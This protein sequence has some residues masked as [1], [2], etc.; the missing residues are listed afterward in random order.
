[1][2][3]EY[4]H[5]LSDLDHVDRNRSSI[6]RW[7]PKRIES[8]QYD[9]GGIIRAEAVWYT[10]KPLFGYSTTRAWCGSDHDESYCR[11]SGES[12]ERTYY[13]AD[14]LDREDGHRI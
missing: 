3:P 8:D 11:G 13:A 7:G 1:M 9:P 5:R 12:A 6:D 4:T 10:G 14:R 2:D